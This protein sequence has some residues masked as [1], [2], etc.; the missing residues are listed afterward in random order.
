MPVIFA[1]VACGILTLLALG[2]LALALGAPFGRFVW[3]GRVDTLTRDLRVRSGV[4]ILLFA[5]GILVELQAA[6]ILTVLNIQVGITAAI[7]MILILFLG[8][9]VSAF[10]QNDNEKALM[11]PVCLVLAA[12]TLFVLVTGH[13]PR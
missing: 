1:L 12:L 7:I 13:L 2:H 10:S 4:A 9:V 5:L 11:T 8:F 3:G 6:D